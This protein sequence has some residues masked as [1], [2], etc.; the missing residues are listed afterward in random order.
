M[1]RFRA[2]PAVP[3]PIPAGNRKPP[4]DRPQGPGSESHA[5]IYKRIAQALDTQRTGVRVRRMP[6]TQLGWTCLAA[7]SG[8]SLT[9]T[10][11]DISLKGYA[12]ESLATVRF[13]AHRRQRRRSSSSGRSGGS[14]GLSQHCSHHLQAGPGIANIVAWNDWREK[15]SCTKHIQSNIGRPGSLY[16]INMKLIETKLA[17]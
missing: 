9:G 17:E 13:H 10:N 16:E 3:R 8:I 15:T 11:S 2:E 12:L 1:N 14:L 4:C 7:L 6:R 5:L